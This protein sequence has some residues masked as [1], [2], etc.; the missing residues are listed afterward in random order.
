VPG[1]VIHV[2]ATA[3]YAVLAWHFWNTRWRVRPAEAAPRKP[4]L[5]AIERAALAVALALHGMLIYAEL[6]V[7][8]ELR[9]GFAQALSVTLWLGVVIYWVESLFMHLDGFEPLLLPLAAVCAALPA[10]FPGR[11]A[12]QYAG[13]LEFTLHVA[14][15]MLASGVLIIAILHVALMASLER[16]LHKPQGTALTR[17]ASFPP[18]LTLERLLFRM[19]AVAFVLL[20]LALGMGIA[21]SES[22]YGRAFRFD[23]KT[24]FSVLTWVTLAVLLF[25]RYAWGWRG[26]TALR[27]A[28]A[29][30]A[31]LM[32]AYVGKSFVLE[33]IL[34]RA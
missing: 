11:V 29:A 18:L 27:W 1:I 32:L 7:A 28:M 4:G 5:S 33:V 12:M 15:G 25:G 22:I 10:A 3:L 6:F 2:A 8:P 24:L 16:S 34:G 19:V 26:R 30:F 14:L 17:L 23:H 20:T 31:F 9:F 13:N 21:F